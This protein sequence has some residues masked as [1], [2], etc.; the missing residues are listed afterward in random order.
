MAG[1][2]RGPAADRGPRSGVRRPAHGRRPAHRFDDRSRLDHRWIDL[3]GRALRARGRPVGRDPRDHAV[4]LLL[5]GPADRPPIRGAAMTEERATSRAPKIW[6]GVLVWLGIAV[7]L[8]AI[9]GSD[10]K[11]DEFKPQNEF[12]LDAWI[13]IHIGGVDL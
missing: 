1:A 9:F 7:L 6:I 11:N 2:A 8:Y 10:G 13:P 3:R 4:H 5:H 12:K